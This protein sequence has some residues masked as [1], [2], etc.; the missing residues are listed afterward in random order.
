MQITKENL[1][2]IIVTIKSQNIIEDCLKSID[3]DIKKKW[4]DIA[5]SQVGLTKDATTRR[6]SAI[7]AEV[8]ARTMES[9]VNQAKTPKWT[10][11]YEQAVREY[12][13]VYNGILAEGGNDLQAHKEAI[14]AVKD[15][16]WKETSPGVYQWDTRG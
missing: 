9:D 12:D 14:A 7:S 3:P 6:N 13:A 5:K 4:M 8:T 10:S 11:N 1:T 2:I 15:G 16:L